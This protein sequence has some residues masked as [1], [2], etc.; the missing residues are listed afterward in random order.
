MLTAKEAK[1]ATEENHQNWK[2]DS[3]KSLQD[4]IN[5][6]I[7]GGHYMLQAILIDEEREQFIKLG[8]TV[9]KIGSINSN[10]YNIHW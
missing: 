3:W 1:D 6:R 4:A 5:E 2:N 10:T 9:K 7:T 8:Y